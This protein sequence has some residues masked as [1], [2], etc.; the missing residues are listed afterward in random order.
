MRIWEGSI[1]K[2]WASF[3]R[4]LTVGLARLFSRRYIKWREM[5]ES[6]ASCSWLKFFSFR[7]V[8]IAC[9]TFICDRTI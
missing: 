7:K 3:S 6:K 9:P 2:A 1:P 8:M 5:P 4:V